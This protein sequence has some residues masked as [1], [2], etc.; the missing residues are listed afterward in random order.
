MLDRER[1]YY[2]QRR[3]KLKEKYQNKYIVVVG[4]RIVGV[5]DTHAE[6][7]ADSRITFETG[8]FLIC[9]TALPHRI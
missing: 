9:N 1:R 4:R 6:A 5:Y 2:N 7:F 8:A 3:R